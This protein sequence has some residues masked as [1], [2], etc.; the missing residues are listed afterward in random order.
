MEDEEPT[1]IDDVVVVGRRTDTGNY[2]VSFPVS[3]G[4]RETF[5]IEQ[6]IVDQH[7][8]SSGT[9][10][11]PNSQE[12]FEQVGVF[13]ITELLKYLKTLPFVTPQEIAKLND[14]I[15]QFTALS[16]AYA[17]G[18]IS[19][20]NFKSGVNDGLA[21]LLGQVGD[22]IGSAITG[23]IVGAAAAAGFSPTGPGGLAAGAVGIAVGAAIAS[24]FPSEALA[25]V[26]TDIL[27]GDSE[28]INRLE[29]QL[30][31]RLEDRAFDFYQELIDFLYRHQPEDAPRPLA[32]RGMVDSTIDNGVAVYAGSIGHDNISF[33]AA[34]AAVSVDMAIDNVQNSGG[35]GLIRMLTID[36]VFGSRFNDTLLGN[37]MD[38]V[39]A[40]AGGDD[41]IDGRGGF[42][43]ADYRLAV[44]AVAVSLNL[45]VQNTGGAGTDTL[46]N[47][48]GIV[49]SGHGDVLTG[50]S[51][52]NT[53]YG[54]GG[55]DTLQ[56][57]DGDDLLVGGD[58]FDIL[59]GGAGFDTVSYETETRDLAVWLGD[60][61]QAYKLPDFVYEWTD[62]LFSIEGVIGGSGNDTLVGSAGNNQIFGNAGSDT[63]QG[64]DGDDLIEGGAGDD[65]LT[66]GAGFDTLSYATSAS[67]VSINLSAVQPDWW[68]A[69]WANVQTGGAG[70]DQLQDH[71]EGLLGSLHDD[72]LIGN[73]LD[74][75]IRGSA[76]ND[77]LEGMA[78]NDRLIGG[79]GGDILVGGIG[80][81]RFVF[82]RNDD[83][84]VSNRDV[85]LDFEAGVDL[86]DVSALGISSSNVSFAISGSSALVNVD[87][88]LDGIIDL[89]IEVQGA[90]GTFGLGNMDFQ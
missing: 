84:P 33:A 23:G 19:R 90:A 52:S 44:A 5:M 39:F 59:D 41:Y 28:T 10:T 27:F 88:N 53:L 82:E 21:F 51:G 1:N 42:D 74:N 49:G 35:G 45:S 26:L 56:G 69:G 81:D 66:G 70:I 54:M 50:N 20:D 17:A 67:G 13:I 2:F 47:I 85:I 18:D 68:W 7:I 76:G 8:A 34:A 6:S 65:T 16:T 32:E 83:S 79:E 11:E 25:D 30:Q 71:F 89:S 29:N 3:G 46:I 36:G 43:Y 58:G 77:R 61:N 75:D 14:I 86:I 55:D 62:T 80:A 87:F 78:G 38:N 73:F 15:N 57:G 9:T 60:G 4:G 48:E 64:G 24:A 22:A 37:A 63:L 31:E 72:V 12:R 40:G